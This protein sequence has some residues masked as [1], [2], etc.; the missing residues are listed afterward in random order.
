MSGM[1]GSAQSNSTYNS[2]PR[3]PLAPRNTNVQMGWN[4]TKKASVTS[5]TRHDSTA[6]SDISSVGDTDGNT[7]VC[8]C[9]EDARLLT[10][11][12]EGPNTGR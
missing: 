3:A 1:S 5:V 11:R 8:Q 4:G 12:K 6:T 10:V 7:I 9:G 2:Q